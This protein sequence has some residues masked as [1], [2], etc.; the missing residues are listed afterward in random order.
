LITHVFPLVIILSNYDII[1]KNDIIPENKKQI[2]NSTRKKLSFNI[3]D[4]L[5]FN[6]DTDLEFLTGLL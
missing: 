5:F 2:I 3:F 4:L 1:S 6:Y